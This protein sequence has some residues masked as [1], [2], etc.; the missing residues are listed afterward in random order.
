MNKKFYFALV[1]TAA[2]FAG[3]SSDEI[4]EAP[5]LNGVNGNGEQTPIVINVSKAGTTRGTGTVG[6]V[7]GAANTWAGQ[8]FNLFMFE[9]GTLIPAQIQRTAGAGLEDIYNNA[10]LKTPIAANGPAIYEIGG[11][12]SSSYYPTTGSFDFW[13]YRIDDAGTGTGGVGVPEGLGTPGSYT[14]AA[15][16]GTDAATLSGAADP[17]PGTIGTVGAIYENTTSGD[18]FECTAIVAAVDA[19]ADGKVVIP[20]EINGSQDIMIG[21]PKTADAK[22]A[23]AAN[24]DVVAAAAKETPAVTA[25]EYAE[26]KIYS[27]YAARRGVN[28]TLA[29]THQLTRLTFSV[30]AASREVSDKATCKYAPAP[31]GW[32][33]GFTITGVEVKSKSKS[34]LIA[35]YKGAAPASYIDWSKDETGA[36]SAELWN[37]PTTLATLNLMSRKKVVDEKAMIAFVQAPYGAANVVVSAAANAYTN[38]NDGTTTFTAATSGDKTMAEWVAMGYVYD[39]DATDAT[40]GKPSGNVLTSAAW[41]TSGNVY[42][43]VVADGVHSDG[44]TTWDECTYDPAA[45]DANEQLIPLETV[46]PKWTGFTA[47]T[48]A[49]YKA[50]DASAT[51][52]DETAFDAE[53]DATKFVGGTLATAKGDAA[54][55]DAA[56]VAANEGKYFFVTG[57]KAYKIEEDAAAVAEV[58]GNAVE[59]PVGEA[60]LVAPADANGYHVTIY[61]TRTKCIDATKVEL[62]PGKAELNVIRK[63]GLAGATDFEI[64]KTYNI[65]V[66][67]YKDAETEFTVDDPTP[68]VPGDG[69]DDE[70][71]GE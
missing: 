7:S 5:S 16:T 42:I 60:L 31:A 22:T 4:A 33:A 55:L 27:A 53:A 65:K 37:D 58:P 11:V 56:K 13:A 1:A 26:T 49:T 8:E 70:Y 54:A 47:G 30:V 44:V 43:L 32:D 63:A 52:A 36:A 15:Y 67:L 2:L 35:A 20:F 68:W 3:C 38:K 48:P 9:K 64:G 23:L 59:T 46:K 19:A 21:T 57:D 66:K 62:L 24:A 34:Q 39:S 40:T 69:I 18:K 12:A 28:P 10:V 71:S 50:T 45:E 61:Y 14:W 17:T 41:P 6:N 25:E 51:Y 29:F